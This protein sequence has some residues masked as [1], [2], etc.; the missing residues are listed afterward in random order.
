MK[1][2]FIIVNP[3]KDV[4]HLRTTM[5]SIKRYYNNSEVV[6]ILPKNADTQDIEESK[7]FCRSTYRGGDNEVK[8]INTGFRKFKGEWGTIIRAGSI[9]REGM[10]YKYGT[11]LKDYKDIFYPITAGA[12][13]NFLDSSMNGLTINQNFFKKVGDFPENVMWK[14]NNPEF[15]IFKVLWASDAQRLGCR[16]KAVLGCYP[17]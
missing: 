5:S 14:A 7:I 9:L 10:Q 17:L 13:T 8:M 15:N 4:S 16:F 2:G 11:H 3:E 1:L 6:H 12:T